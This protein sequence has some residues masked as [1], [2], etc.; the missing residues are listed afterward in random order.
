MDSPEAELSILIVDDP[1]IERLNQEYLQR[2]GPTNVIAFPMQSGKFG[3]ISPQ[4]LGDVVISV[5]TAQRE[6]EQ[7]GMDLERR[8]DQLLIHGILHLFGYDHVNDEHS[9]REMENKTTE[10]LQ[11]VTRF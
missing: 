9:A 5:E 3:H 8:M 10:L 1:D 7:G 6:S 4:L 2:S 11:L